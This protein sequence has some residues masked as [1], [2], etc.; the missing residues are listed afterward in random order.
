MCLYL[1]LPLY[2]SLS[3][4][5]Y[6]YRERDLFLSLSLYLYVYIYIYIHTGRDEGGPRDA[7]DLAR[8][9]SGRDRDSR[10]SVLQYSYY[11]Y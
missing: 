1:S 2:L 9:A 5:I 10:F 11:Y 8:R 3:L 6:I 4:Y 7:E